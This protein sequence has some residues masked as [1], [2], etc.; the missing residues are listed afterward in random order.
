MN[1]KTT[2]FKTKKERGRVSPEILKNKHNVVPRTRCRQNTGSSLHTQFFQVADFRGNGS[3]KIGQGKDQLSQILTISNFCRDCSGGRGVA[4]PKRVQTSKK[5]HRSRNST[6]KAI[7]FKQGL[8]CERAKDIRVCETYCRRRQ[9][10]W[11]HLIFD[12]PSFVKL[13][14]SGKGPANSLLPTLMYSK[15]LIDSIA[16]LGK[17]PL[18]PA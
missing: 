6:S 13:E 11:A 5:A 18:N 4:K 15:L 17:V 8:F 2:A 1:Q 3:G 7:P 16:E 9:N 14:K 10:G 12:L